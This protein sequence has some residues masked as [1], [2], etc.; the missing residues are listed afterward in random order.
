M[1]RDCTTKFLPVRTCPA[2][3]EINLTNMY[4]SPSAYRNILVAKPRFNG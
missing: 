1:E 3:K 2:L 4:F